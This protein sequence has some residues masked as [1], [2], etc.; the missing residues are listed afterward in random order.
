MA[1]TP[2][3]RLFPLSRLSPP[4]RLRPG[5]T[6]QVPPRPPPGE[7]LGSSFPPSN[8]AP[9]SHAHHC[10]ARQRPPA[11]DGVPQGSFWIHDTPAQSPA[12]AGRPCGHIQLASIW[13]VPRLCPLSRRSIAVL[14]AVLTA[15][16]VVGAIVGA[17][18]G[19][20]AARAKG[21]PHPPMTSGLPKNNP[22]NEDSVTLLAGARSQ[23]ATWLPEKSAPET[24]GRLLVFQDADGDLAISQW[25]KDKVETYRLRR[26]LAD[27]PKPLLGAPLR[28]LP[29]GRQNDLHLFYLDQD[30]LLRHLMRP[31]GGASDQPWQI[32]STF[33]QDGPQRRQAQGYCLATAVFPALDGRSGDGFLAVLYWNGDGQ[34]SFTMLTAGNPDQKTRWVSTTIVLSAPAAESNQSLRLQHDSPGLLLLPKSTTSAAGELV[35]SLRVIWDLA[36]E[37]HS[38]SL[39][40]FDCE[41]RGRPTT[42]RC[43]PQPVPWKGM[44][45]VLWLDRCGYRFS[46]EAGVGRGG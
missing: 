3:Y 19:S 1:I 14:A 37:T 21:S 31:G 26:R 27:L 7:S 4:N 28:L 5:I 16:L 46:E 33:S 18:V 22:G 42:V 45:A 38:S 36:N 15:V 2:T 9:A 23:L 32:D 8:P 24:V 20:R 12:Y 10:A 13:P 39:G 43:S 34:N 17:I 41:M 30:R 6:N 40:F 29:F 25:H 11:A 35:P 44:P